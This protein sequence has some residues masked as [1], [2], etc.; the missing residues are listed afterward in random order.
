[1]IL[2]YF[3]AVVPTFRLILPIKTNRAAIMASKHDNALPE[4]RIFD[5]ASLASPTED[6]PPAERCASDKH[7]DFDYTQ[8]A[9]DR[10]RMC[11]SE[12]CENFL[13]KSNGRLEKKDS[14]PGSKTV[15]E[16]GPKTELDGISRL[17]Y[18]SKEHRDED[19]TK[20]AVRLEKMRGAVKTLLECVGEDVDREGLLNTP[21]R[22]AQ[23]LLFMTK[24]YQDDVQDAT[25][26]ALFP[27]GHDE[28][29]IV[30]DIDISSLCEHHLVPF[31][32]KAG[33]S[34]S[35]HEFQTLNL[36]DKGLLQLPDAHRLC[37]FWHCHR[38]FKAPPNC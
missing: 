14:V 25:N 32:G 29:V 4:K 8:D 5:H 37:P 11:D 28:I 2:F 36:Q 12:N 34:L 24:G 26:N 7:N 30:K 22:Y 20:L 38:P 1:M 31:I 17:T 33:T 35:L 16:G 10:S 13:C 3:R 15:I 21:L 19:E 18:G 6:D 23:T 9:A 27:E